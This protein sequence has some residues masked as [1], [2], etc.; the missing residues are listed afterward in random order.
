MAET[1]A[2]TKGPAYKRLMEQ[3]K[4]FILKEQ[5]RPNEDRLP[6]AREIEDMF[7]ST[8]GV[9]RMALRELDSEGIIATGQGKAAM[10]LRRPDQP[11]ERRSAE[12]VELKQLIC[13][14]RGEVQSLRA[15]VAEIRDQNAAT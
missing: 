14:L 15:E 12:F 8:A 13:D 11:D 10:V 5:L 6:S 3:I 9:V 4:A 1:P 2:P 7:N